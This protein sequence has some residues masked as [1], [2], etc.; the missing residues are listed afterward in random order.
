MYIESD[1]VLHI[2]DTATK[3]QAARW[4]QNLSAKHTW[5]T[6]CSCWID[7]YIG[8]PDF[9]V[10]DAGTNFT[11]KE[12]YQ[13]AA[14]MAISVNNFLVE[15]HWSVGTVE[16]YHTLVRR[17]YSIMKEELKN[18]G[19]NKTCMLQMTMKAINDS[20]GLNSLVP[21]LLVFGAYP[22]FLDSDPPVVI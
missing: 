1:P 22:R 8:P 19:T 14:S 17:S 16:Q 9:I 18:T 13:S 10:T 4:L 6:I 20:A 3:F 21:T 11:S 2:V 5:D 15:A 12:F 7:V